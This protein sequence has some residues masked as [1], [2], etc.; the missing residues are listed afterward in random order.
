MSKLQ[1]LKRR[2]VFRVGAAYLAGS[3]LLIQLMSNIFPFFGFA[4]DA[5]RPVVVLLAIGFV[6]A[7]VLA[8]VFQLTPQGIR[9]DRGTSG[10]AGGTH[11]TRRFDRS[12]TAALVFAVA[13]FAVDRFVL[14]P[15]RD[16]ELV[17]ATA[18]RVAT[19]LK[20][21][22]ASDKSVAVL[23]FTDLSEAGDQSWLAD[24]LTVEIQN[25][26]NQL[27]ELDVTAQASSFQ[28]RG[29]NQDVGEIAEKLGVANIVQGSVRR[30]G[31]RLRITAQLIRARDGHG[32]W[33]NV[34]DSMSEDVLDV[35]RDVAE[36]IA[37]A[38]D[39][40]LDDER[41]AAM[42]R[43]GTRNVE[44]FENAQRGWAVYWAV[45]NGARDRTLWDANDLFEKALAVDPGYANAAFGAIDAYVHLWADGPRGFVANAPYPEEEAL[46]RLL[47]LIDLAI[48]GSPNEATRVIAE[49]LK[50]LY[51]P[52][53]YRML[54]LIER[55]R[56]TPDLGS[57][58]VE[59]M[60]NVWPLLQFTDNY[61]LM[62]EMTDHYLKLDPLSATSW[63]TRITVE[64]QTGNLETAT[65]MIQQARRTIG[66]HPVFQ[67]FEFQ[68]NAFADIA[69]GGSGSSERETT[70]AWLEA[71]SPD[72][73]NDPLIA[74]LKGEYERALRLAEGVESASRR[75]VPNLINVYCLAGD[76]DAA[77]N[78]MRRIDALPAGPA[79]LLAFA[80]QRRNDIFKDFSATPNFVRQLRQAGLDPASYPGDCPPNGPD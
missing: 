44:A 78:L 8:W 54:T 39:I 23:P 73:A 29:E 77:R 42:L 5:G 80:A 59:L 60:G 20:G 1:E 31:E 74:A 66:D 13:L 21:V 7:L 30:S 57:V 55:L 18:E 33:S 76:Y 12:I 62:R 49:L 37:S 25:A 48:E 34:Y 79:H 56:D 41:R 65:D 38:L 2:N 43:S 71:N 28:F 3:W 64:L 68:T 46:S 15:V 10:G 69:H 9:R 4:A 26:L 45:H 35:Q 27:S 17:A 53:W 75:P 32:L 63:I 58:D 70:I 6:P 36:Q 11:T 47:D 40:V 61:P 22:A 14:D 50:E 19:D 72:S 52:T 67:Y 51:S 24:G 16:A